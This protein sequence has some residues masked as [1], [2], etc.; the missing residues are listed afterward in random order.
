MPL[1]LQCLPATNP[2]TIAMAPPNPSL[3]LSCPSEILGVVFECLTTTDLHAV[4]LICRDIHALAER[5]LYYSVIWRWTDKDAPPI[6]LLLR[7]LLRRPDLAARIRRLDLAGT[8]LSKSRPHFLP[9]HISV[10]EANLAGPITFVERLNVP[11]G[12]DWIR[13]LQD[14]EMGAFVAV[15]VAQVPN[16]NY[17]CLAPDFARDTLFLGLLFRSALCESLNPGL[18]AF[19]HLR[20][21]RQE[22]PS[23]HP[24]PGS[25]RRTTGDLLPMFYLP[26]LKF[27][28]AVIE[29]PLGAAF[30]WPA[31]PPPLGSTLTHLAVDY[32]RE[33]DLGHI[34]RATP[35]LETLKW[36]C[37]HLDDTLKPNI[38]DLDQIG[39]DLSNVRNTLSDLSIGASYYREIFG[40]NPPLE[41]TGSLHA[42]ADFPSLTRYTA[43]LA[44]F[45]GMAPPSR[46]PLE[47]MLPRTV[48]SLTIRD[49]LF[50]SSFRW[51]DI[52]VLEAMK[53]WISDWKSRTPRLRRFHLYMEQTDN[54]WLPPIMNKLRELCRGTGLPCEI[55]KFPPF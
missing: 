9:S 14:G 15:L 13:A 45:V 5:F 54:Q 27:I 10:P 23:S 36:R 21:I 51:S 52:D 11:Y 35:A 19:R 25:M 3:L 42:I 34:L 49:D 17:L 31:G 22:L 12:G 28:S 8:H 47:Q 48:E 37:V 43:P 16:L 53:P 6:D 50:R 4:C 33:G 29:N 38:I 7:T 41:T 24:L 32:V 46:L 20:E 2:V 55:T 1:N 40:V 30:S 39:E 26:S 18:P 44:F